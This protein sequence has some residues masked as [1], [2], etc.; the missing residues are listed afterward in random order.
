MLRALQSLSLWPERAG[1]SAMRLPRMT[2][3]RA[4]FIAAANYPS[5]VLASRVEAVY[6]I[7]VL[8]FAILVISLVML[9]G[10][11]NRATAYLGL[12]TGYCLSATGSTGLAC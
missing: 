2:P 4:A 10:V 7:V 8:S 9:R 1:A 6:A 5:A 11:F 3:Q 12:A